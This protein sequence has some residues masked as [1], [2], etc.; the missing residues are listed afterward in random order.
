LSLSQILHTINY[1]E[2]GLE[3]LSR[4]RA[5]K[6]MTLGSQNK[7]PSYPL[8]FTE[9]RNFVSTSSQNSEFLRP[10]YLS[11]FQGP[12]DL[13]QKNTKICNFSLF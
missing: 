13:H 9:G 3:F 7:F 6:Q 4:P 2:S 1:N 12:P 5:P 8:Q 11:N 10:N